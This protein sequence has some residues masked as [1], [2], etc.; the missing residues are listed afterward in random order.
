MPN[1]VALAAAKTAEAALG[2][3]MSLTFARDTLEKSI[4]MVSEEIGLPIEILGKDLELDGITKNQSFGLEERNQTADAVLRAILARSN[5]DG[6]LV[7]VIRSRDG[8]ES[9]EITTRAAAAK[10]KDP[11]PAVFADQPAT[12]AMKTDDKKKPATRK[13]AE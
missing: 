9:I 13:D 5:P 7:Y 6:K 10:R 2:R 4:Q 3:K 1:G 8:V 11:L 12:Q